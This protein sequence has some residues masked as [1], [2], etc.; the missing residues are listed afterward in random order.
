MADEVVRKTTDTSSGTAKPA[1][2]GGGPPEKNVLHKYRSFTY[3]FTIAALNSN[4]VS[5]P[6]TYN[7]GAPLQYVILKSGGK[8][9]TGIARYGC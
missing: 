2:P 6:K 8:G 9:G 1:V 3:L 5:D 7:G 4:Q